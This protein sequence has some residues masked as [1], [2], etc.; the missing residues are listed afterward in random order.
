MVI[1]ILKKTEQLMKQKKIGLFFSLIF[2]SSITTAETLNAE[3]TFLNVQKWGLVQPGTTCIEHYT[4]KPTTSEVFISSNQEMVTGSY[5]F[6]EAQ[7]KFELPAIVISFE[8]DNQ[9]PDCAGNAENQA[10][11]STTNFLKKVSDQKIF[12]CND[13]L[14]KQ[15]SVYLIP[16]K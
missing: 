7:N 8:T 12:F 4:F 16:E 14:G 1:N 11:T 9:K 6:V 10:G 2:L 5:R 15:C 13:A 3:R